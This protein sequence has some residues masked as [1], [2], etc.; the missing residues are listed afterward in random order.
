[1]APPSPRTTTYDARAVA[2]SFLELGNTESVPIT[3]MAI[4]KLVYFAHG[5]MLAVYGRPL[6]EQRIMAWDYGPVIHDLYT[7]FKRFGDRA[8][9]EPAKIIQ[10]MGMKFRVT[11][12]EIPKDQDPEATHL[13][14]QVWDTYKHFTAIQLSNM[15]HVPG[16]PWS[17]ARE[18]DQPFIDDDLP[19]KHTSPL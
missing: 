13:L 16:S 8:I 10:T 3:P 12:P 14:G 7:E 4:Q 19:K 6:I 18:N 11:H 17:I 2:N 1:M 5:W 9:T 15:T